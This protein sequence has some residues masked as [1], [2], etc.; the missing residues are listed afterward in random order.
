MMFSWLE[1]TA[2]AF[3]LSVVLISFCIFARTHMQKSLYPPSANSK[4]YVSL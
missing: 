2:A 3:G 1:I 4:I